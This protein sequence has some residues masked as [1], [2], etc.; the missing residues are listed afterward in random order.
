MSGS[1]GSRLLFARS[2]WSEGSAPWA[3]PWAASPELVSVG[4]LPNRGVQ[5][6]GKM[7]L[8]EEQALSAQRN[9]GC[10]LLGKNGAF[11]IC[12]GDAPG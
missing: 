4:T 12:V 10:S 8:A 3:A 11:L 1:L 2:V 9:A 5:R 6:S 7:L